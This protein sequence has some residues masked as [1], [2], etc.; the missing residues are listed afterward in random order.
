MDAAAKKQR[1]EIQAIK[2]NWPVVLGLL[3]IFIPTL[4]SLANGPWRQSEYAHG[5]IVLLTA[6]WLFWQLRDAVIN[7]ESLPENRLGIT[8]LIF[9]CLLYALG[10]SQTILFIEVGS[11]IP[12]ILGAVV[13][14]KGVNAAK[15]LWFPIFFL[16]FLVPLPGFL[17]DVLTGPL[18]N[19]V[20]AIVSELLYLLGYPIARNGV[21]LTIGHYQL[22]IADACSGLNSM[23]TLTALGLLFVYLKRKTTTARHITLMVLA[24]L[25]IA[26]FTNVAR[27]IALSLLTYYF[28]DEAGLSF[29]HDVAAVTEFFIAL[30]LLVTLDST[31]AHLAGKRADS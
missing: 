21:V 10:R 22:L 29:S 27:V 1:L 8:L 20:S 19:Q 30:L 16:L 6:L 23:Y 15:R 7:S 3:V 5:P 24:I 13:L 18:K 17:I 11:A 9:G 26:F 25:P 4:L 12:I 2:E 31:L 28:G 14:T